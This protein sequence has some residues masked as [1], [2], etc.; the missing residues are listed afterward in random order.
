MEVLHSFLKSSE[1]LY[2]R[3][4]NSVSDMFLISILLRSLAVISVL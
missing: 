4:L 1:D 3:Y 2:K